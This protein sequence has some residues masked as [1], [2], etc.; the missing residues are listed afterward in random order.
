M[1]QPCGIFYWPCANFP[2]VYCMQFS[3]RPMHL[4]D[5]PAVNQLTRQLGY[6]LSVQQ[7]VNQLLS[8]LSSPDHTAFVATSDEVVLGWIHAFQP[9]YIESLPFVEIGGLVVDET[10]RGVGIG[11]ALVE[12][13]ED[14]CLQQE[15]Y[16]IRVRSQAKRTG[17]H[18]FYAGLHFTEV[19]EQKVFQLLLENP[20]KKK[21]S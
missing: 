4:K 13:V 18:A 1:P 6:S 15:I 10:S 8:I 5:A 12:V 16:T 19:K 11:K 20:E 3:I 9:L 14:W 7:T 21:P 17:A 2:Y